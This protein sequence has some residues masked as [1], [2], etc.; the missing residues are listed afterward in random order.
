[1]QSNK[2]ESVTSKNIEF[3]ESSEKMSIESTE[4]STNKKESIQVLT[5]KNTI[6]EQAI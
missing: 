2:Q 1:M 4:K 6:P 5:E 3:S